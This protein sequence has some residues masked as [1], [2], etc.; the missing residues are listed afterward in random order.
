MKRRSLFVVAAVLMIITIP[1][2]Y[3]N[4]YSSSLSYFE[5]DVAFRKKVLAGYLELSKFLVESKQERRL[6]KILDDGI[7]VGMFDWYIIS[8]DG[9]PVVYNPP[10]MENQKV[11][12][13]DGNFNDDESKIC[14]TLTL[15]DGSY[16]T[17]GINKRWISY[18]QK[19]LKKNFWLTVKENA[20]AIFI[21]LAIFGYLLKDIIKITRALKSG[22]GLGTLGE[23]AGKYSLT[24]E[25]QVFSE[26]MQGYQQSVDRLSDEK[27]VL[28]GQVLPSL[29]SELASGKTPPYEFDCVMVRT[30]INRY[31]QMFAMGGRTERDLLMSVVHRFFSQATRIV[32]RYGGYMHEFV[33]DELIFYFKDSEVENAVSMALGCL[34]EIQQAALSYDGEIEKTFQLPFTIKSSLASGKL[35][36]GPLVNGFS[37]AGPP[38]IESVRILSLIEDRDKNQI[39]VAENVKEKADQT[40]SFESKGDFLL[41]GYSHNRVVYEL[42]QRQA[43][44]VVLSGLNTSTIQSLGSFRAPHEML[45][46]FRFLIA[47]DKLSS[48]D[49][50]KV[51]M[52]YRDIYVES[53]Y[54]DLRDVLM[55]LVEHFRGR[56]GGETITPTVI[57]MTVSLVTKD[58]YQQAMKDFFMESLDVETDRGIANTLEA[59][60]HFE[61]VDIYGLYRRFRDKGSAR[62]IGNILLLWGERQITTELCDIFLQRLRSKDQSVVASCLY[63]FAE[64]VHYWLEKDLVY[65]RAQVEFFDLQNQIDKIIKN[66]KL[67]SHEPV[68]RQ[69][70]RAQN[71]I[72]ALR[73]DRV[74][75]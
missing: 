24:K 57:R 32:S 25:G 22:K 19:I 55:D 59:Y 72:S 9:V 56:P 52:L 15:V 61:N 66:P 60:G 50:L 71:S 53:S 17:I 49:V 33:G 73:Q 58:L 4:F 16:I 14:A 74:N 45:R 35:R 62:V 64:I 48:G 28:E 54:P 10:E 42:M 1:I 2:Y 65:L 34:L 11:V 38:L 75:L 47:T 69:A 51:L 40:F 21:V 7:S 27:Q 70:M 26:I 18:M 6:V 30:D 37:L 12:E 43:L 29:R 41:K 39:F 3:F 20:L 36:Y 31:S 8:K 5:E 68:H 13:K 23:S 44:E 63:A 46:I 67:M